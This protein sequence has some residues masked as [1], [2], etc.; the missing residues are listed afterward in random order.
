MNNQSVPNPRPSMAHSP[1][2]AGHG[3]HG[4]MMM[5]CCIP[6]IAIA[7]VLVAAGVA[8]PGFLVA[9]A[10][11]TVML[12]MMMRAMDHGGGHDHT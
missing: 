11:C 5:I 1:K 10:G 2:T 7:I 3:S 6:M 4:W 12:A 9:A 8:S